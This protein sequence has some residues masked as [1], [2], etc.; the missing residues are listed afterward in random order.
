LL[1]PLSKSVLSAVGKFL[2]PIAAAAIKQVSRGI[3]QEHNTE[4][5]EQDDLPAGS[6]LQAQALITSVRFPS[7]VK[8]QR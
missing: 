1:L 5:V 8:G 7:F 4:Q 3:V 2:E 6:T